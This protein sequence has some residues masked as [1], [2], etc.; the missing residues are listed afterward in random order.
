MG[1]LVGAYLTYYAME[2]D[3]WI[4]IYVSLGIIGAAVPVTLLIPAASSKP[5][6]KPQS[7]DFA[8]AESKSWTVKIRSAMADS[9]PALRWMFVENTAASIVIATLILTSLG[10][11][12]KILEM[13][14]LTKVFGVSWAEV[15]SF[16]RSAFTLYSC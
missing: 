15:R 8:P 2:V 14:Y 16:L 6:A 13:Q 3:P 9:K 7:V 10:L 1:K 4:S 11:Y 5:K 12:A